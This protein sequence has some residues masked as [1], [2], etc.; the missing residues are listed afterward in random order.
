MILLIFKQQAKVFG[1]IICDG[2][3]SNCGWPPK[4]LLAQAV[5]VISLVRYTNE[6]GRKAGAHAQ[7]RQCMR[8]EKDMTRARSL[9]RLHSGLSVTDIIYF[10]LFL[11][12]CISY[13]YYNI[14]AK[15][16][17]IITYILLL[18]FQCSVD[19]TFLPINNIPKK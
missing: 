1:T 14:I 13:I 10:V 19:E 4:R 15:I 17:L 12:L 3:C 9:K 11:K 8:T 7:L 16:H 6:R 18:N 2:L 5:R